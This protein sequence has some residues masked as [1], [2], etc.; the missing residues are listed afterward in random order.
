MLM[1]PTTM[2]WTFSGCPTQPSAFPAEY[3]F[4]GVVLPMNEL[5]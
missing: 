2:L 5:I 3:P 1:A 4:I